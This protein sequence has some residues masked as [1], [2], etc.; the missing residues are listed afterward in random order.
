MNE[1]LK[2]LSISV[3]SSAVDYDEDTC[4]P[5]YFVYNSQVKNFAASAEFWNSLLT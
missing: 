1:T 5:K 3:N 2:N 4:K